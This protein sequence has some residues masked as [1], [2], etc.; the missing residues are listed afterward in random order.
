MNRTFIFNLLKHLGFGDSFINRI[1]MLYYSANMHIH[2]NDFLTNAIPIQRRV[3]Q[4][5]A[6]SPMLY[7]LCMEVL[8]CKVSDPPDITE[9]SYNT[10][11]PCK[12][13]ALNGNKRNN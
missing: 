10:F 9:N 6:L 4:G 8:S 2:V 3:R 5:E 12:R 7:I 11:F 13:E 1:H